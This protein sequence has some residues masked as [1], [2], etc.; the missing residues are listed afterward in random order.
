M[1]LLERKDSII[2][3][4]VTFLVILLLFLWLF[5]CGLRWDKELLASSSI[6][7]EQSEEE[8]F[9]DPELLMEDAG[10]AQEDVDEGAPMQRGEPEL[11]ETENL[12]VNDP[13]K[14][15]EPDVKAENTV[16]QKKESPVREKEPSVSD[17][18]REKMTSRVN[19]FSPHNG[20]ADGKFNSSGSGGAG[21]GVSGNVS[22]RT[23]LGC[24][25][26]S[27]S[28]KV[29]TIVKVSVTVNAEGHVTSASASGAADASI[30]RQCER[31]ART[32]RWSA[33]K[34]AAQ[35]RGTLTFTITPR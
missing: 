30:R 22:G 20:A 3:G 32:A 11:A 25:K 7:E 18:E 13:G 4:I 15:P 6:P 27:V 33:R 19:K 12:V 31:A 28:L 21:V 5:F 1:T 9:L 17:K 34:G 26:P 16:K 23:F 24:D 2:A 10:G 29:K 35:A 14:N 8:L